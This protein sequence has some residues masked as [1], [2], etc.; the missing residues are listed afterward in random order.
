MS[1]H[2]NRTDK[3]ALLA[4]LLAML[5]LPSVLGALQQGPQR[6]SLAVA[7]TA[8]PLRTPPTGTP[9][10]TLEPLYVLVPPRPTATPT[11]T[12]RWPP[13]IALSEGMTEQEAIE[14]LEEK[15]Q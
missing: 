4:L 5:A 8:T 12:P 1:K 11:P 10:P 6:R 14:W 9:R 7:P 2:V 15:G 13:Y 3:R